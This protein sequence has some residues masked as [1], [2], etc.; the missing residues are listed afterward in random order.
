MS[1]KIEKTIEQL[2]E[3]RRIKAEK[4][5]EYYKKNRERILEKKK[6]YYVNN[7]ET[8][9]KSQMDRYYAKA[10]FLIE[11]SINNAPQITPLRTQENSSSLSGTNTYKEKDMD[12]ANI[13]F[14]IID[15]KN[16]NT[17]SNEEKNTAS[18]FQGKECENVTVPQSTLYI[19]VPNDIKVI[20]IKS[21]NKNI[22]VKRE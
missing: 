14:S 19:N 22:I 12:A 9:L 10:E 2:E 21:S 5:K 17:D 6:E 1:L 3:E 20:I 4:K 7:K 8:I 11:N 15:G 18:V 16:K 13:N